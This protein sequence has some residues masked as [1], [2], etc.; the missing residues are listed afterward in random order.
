MTNA[1]AGIADAG[2]RPAPADKAARRISGLQKN[3]LAISVMLLAQ[4][5]LGMG[6]N[7]YAQVPRADRGRGLA[8]AVGRALSNPPA[9]LAI[10]AALGLLLLVAA[11]SVLYRAV[12]ARHRW[13][14]A[15]SVAG[16]LS[17]AG[18]AFSGASFADHGHP[19]AS[20]AMAVLTAVALLCYLLNL[21][22]LGVS[23]STPRDHRRDGGQ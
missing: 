18:A 8:V 14:V 13:A 1:G 19:G 5:G 12:L 22:A 17:I 10:H 20:M 16:L 7:L 9:V 4:Y 3:S 21:F 2:T 23:A 11:V 6:V 15:A